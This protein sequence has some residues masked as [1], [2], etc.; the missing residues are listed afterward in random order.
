LAACVCLCGARA[1]AA[2]SA[3]RLTD[4]GDLRNLNASYECAVWEDG[5]WDDDR[6]DVFAWTSGNGL[7]AQMDSLALANG[8]AAWSQS[9]DRWGERVS[10]DND[11]VH[12]AM[13]AS[14]DRGGE[15]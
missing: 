8:R 5:S 12:S 11:Q 15:L 14:V 3:Q 1:E 7:S 6:A 2:D 13:V 9:V 10:D 4:Y